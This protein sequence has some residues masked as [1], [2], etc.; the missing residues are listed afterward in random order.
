MVG[1][2]PVVV[3]VVVVVVEPDE[4]VAVVVVPPVVVGGAVHS[5][6]VPHDSVE[7]GSHQ[8]VHGPVLPLLCKKQL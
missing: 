8:I 1:V 7:S 3:V 5:S 6:L 4:L 2:P